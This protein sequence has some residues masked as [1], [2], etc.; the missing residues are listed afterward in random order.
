MRNGGG[1]NYVFA[2]SDLHGNI[3]GARINVF[4]LLFGGVVR[5]R[6]VE[7]FDLARR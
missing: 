1:I 4:L 5:K 3:L 2:S 6:G 7:H